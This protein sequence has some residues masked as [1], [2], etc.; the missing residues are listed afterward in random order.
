[1]T[2][3]ELSRKLNIPEDRFIT[4]SD[5]RIEWV[6]EHKIGHTVF[7]PKIKQHDGTYFEDYVHGCD[8]CCS[9]LYNKEEK[10]GA[11]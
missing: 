10:I 3:K 1:M 9:L 6:C 4:R 11:D 8:G 5:G 2:I 7:A